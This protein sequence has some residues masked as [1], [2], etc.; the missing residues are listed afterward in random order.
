MDEVMAL[1]IDEICEYL[2]HLSDDP[3]LWS[4]VAAWLAENDDGLD[5]V[6]LAERF[7]AEYEE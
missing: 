7:D 3:K 6:S 5:A 1:L 4:R 2:P